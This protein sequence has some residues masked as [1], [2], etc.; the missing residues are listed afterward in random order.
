ML[1]ATT[2]ATATAKTAATDTGTLLAA[3]LHRFVEQ[4]HCW[5]AEVHESEAEQLLVPALTPGSPQD[6][7]YTFK[8]EGQARVTQRP[9]PFGAGLPAADAPV[10]LQVYTEA[11]QVVLTRALLSGL[12]LLP[13]QHWMPSAAAGEGFK[14]KA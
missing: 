5:A 11:G 8:P 10:F 2:V 12:T 1:A 13:T 6:A 7:W 3:G 14:F 4:T 9:G